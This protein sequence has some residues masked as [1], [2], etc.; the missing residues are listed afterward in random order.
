M[1]SA[2]TQSYMLWRGIGLDGWAVALTVSVVC[3]PCASQIFTLVT[4]STQLFHS[5]LGVAVHCEGELTPRLVLR[6]IVSTVFETW[7]VCTV[8]WEDGK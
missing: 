1:G 4:S 2:R 7:D 5:P 3:S 8:R 6:F